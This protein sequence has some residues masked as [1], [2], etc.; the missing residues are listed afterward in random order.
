MIFEDK[1]FQKQSLYVYEVVVKSHTL[2]VGFPLG[3]L[4]LYMLSLF[5]IIIRVSLIWH[6]VEKKKG[7]LKLMVENE[8]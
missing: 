6:E 5:Q 4:L 2:L 1:I 3:M 7:L 8:L